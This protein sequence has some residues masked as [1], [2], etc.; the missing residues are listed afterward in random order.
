M[1]GVTARFPEQLRAAAS[2]VGDLDGLPDH[3][4]IDSVVVLGMGGSGIAGDV[5][6]AVGGPFVPEP[7]SLAVAAVVGL[8]MRRRRR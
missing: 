5:L 3:D 7:S 2:V 1:F 4:A 6:A 8:W